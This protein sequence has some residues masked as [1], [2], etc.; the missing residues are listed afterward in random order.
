VGIFFDLKKAFDV[1]SHE[2]LLK[3]LLKMGIQGV[4]LAWFISYLKDRSQVV[5]INGK[6]SSSKKI[7]ISVLQGSILGPI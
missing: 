2:I 3:K 1:V 7:S 4:A 5:G 6:V